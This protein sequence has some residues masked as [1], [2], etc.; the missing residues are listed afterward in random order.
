MPEVR[1]RARPRLRRSARSASARARAGADGSGGEHGAAG[2]RSSGSVGHGRHNDHVS[3]TASDGPVTAR[4]GSPELFT[5]RT[6][7][8]AGSALGQTALPTTEIRSFWSV[9]LPE[10]ENGVLFL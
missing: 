3:V 2:Q 4:R 8:A 6:S 10:H 7:G 1:R 5:R 9:G